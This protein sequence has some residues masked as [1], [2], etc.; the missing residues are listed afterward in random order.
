MAGA[1]VL[2]AASAPQASI[3]PVLPAVPG[4]WF[5]RRSAGQPQP[6]SGGWHRYVPS[7]VSSTMSAATPGLGLPSLVPAGTGFRLWPAGGLTP[8]RT[9]GLRLS[10]HRDGALIVDDLNG[11][12]FKQPVEADVLPL[13]HD[14][15]RVD[16]DPRRRYRL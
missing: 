10:L 8:T 16:V 5:F 3:G 15:L 11:R 6:E 2:T 7:A 1:A 14:A 9:T 13:I 12:G 4:S